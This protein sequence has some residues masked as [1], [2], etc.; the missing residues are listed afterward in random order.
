MHS[1]SLDADGLVSVA[2]FGS[3]NGARMEIDNEL[4]SARRNSGGFTVFMVAGIPAA[5]GFAVSGRGSAGY[6]VVF[7]DAPT[8]ISSASASP[9]APRTTARTAQTIAAATAL[10]RRVYALGSGH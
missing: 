1:N 3:A 5:H 8:S 6:N 7:T 9:P 4:A 10:Y 2:L